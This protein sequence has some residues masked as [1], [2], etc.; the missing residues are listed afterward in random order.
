MTRAEIEYRIKCLNDEMF[1]DS[2]LELITLRTSTDYTYNKA[3][4][5]VDKNS[6]KKCWY[7]VN[8]K[9]C[10]KTWK[11]ADLF[12]DGFCLAKNTNFD[13]ICER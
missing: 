5:L 7:S 8:Y 6:T 3:I 4:A 2:P 11:D 12:L 10:F 9:N 1:L 13:R